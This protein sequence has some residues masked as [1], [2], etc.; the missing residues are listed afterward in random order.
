MARFLTPI[1]SGSQEATAGERRFGERLKTLLEEDY[2]CWFNVPVGPLHHYPDFVLLHPSRGL[3]VFEVK[4]WRID[5]LFKVDKIKF[6]IHSGD[7]IKSVA[8]PLEQARQYCMTIVNHL[9]S[10]P[11]LRH[12]TGPHQGK[13]CFPYAYAVVLTQITRKQWNESLSPEEQELVLPSRLVICKD[14]MTE[15]TPPD[16]FQE[17]LWGMFHYTFGGRL[18]LPQIDRVRW[19]LF[20]EIR[21]TSVQRDFFAESDAPA[22]VAPNLVQTMDLVQEQVARN[23]GKGHRVIHGVAG[24]GKTLILGYR[25]LQLA[26]ELPKPILVLCFN[27]TLASRLRAFVE[28]RNLQDKVSVQHFH[29]WCKQQ[30]ETYHVQE[31]HPEKPAYERHVDTVIHGVETGF[32]P[33][34]QYGAILIDEGH[35]FAPEWL[36]LI[37]QMLDPETDSLLLL[38]DDAQSIYRSHVTKKFTLSSVGIKAQGRTTILRLNYRNT[39]EI[40]QFAKGFASGFLDELEADEDHIPQLCPEAAGLTGPKPAFYPMPS[41]DEE[42]RYTLECIRHWQKAGVPLNEIAVICMAE[43]YAEEVRDL[44]KGEGIAVRFMANRYGKVSY[45]P[46][47]PRVSVMLAPSSKG[48]EFDCVVVVGV[49]CRKSQSQ[50]QARLTYVAITRARQQLLL[51]SST[52]NPITERLAAL[53][54]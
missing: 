18:T 36:R 52:S 19:H 50:D 37:T 29:G 44:L 14:E 35:D 30:I 27:I 53:M 2:L 20:P 16:V 26:R 39:Q 41:R 38:Y 9:A 47:E 34:A 3:W 28:Q 54:A 25:C 10:D 8:N 12:P 15:T 43:D 42:I 49:G 22:G 32:I 46:A 5:S 1:G 13:L 7:A 4:D 40:L 48:L 45:D 23:L 24:S 33:R 21:I 17:R 11:Q 6:Q 31:I 51:T